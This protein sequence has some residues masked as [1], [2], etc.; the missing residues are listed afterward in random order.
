VSAFPSSPAS[1]DTWAGVEDNYQHN[2]AASAAALQVAFVPTP[3][4]SPLPFTPIHTPTPHNLFATLLTVAEEE[5]NQL[6]AAEVEVV[7]HFSPIASLGNQSPP[8][9]YSLPI[10][11]A[12]LLAYE[13]DIKEEPLGSPIVHTS[14]ATILLPALASH[15]ASPSH[16]TFGNHSASP[17]D[18]T[19]CSP[20]P[21][22]AT[23]SVQP[24]SP[25]LLQLPL[26]E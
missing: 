3:S 17:I 12:S 25:I 9:H 13:Q 14:I 5:H 20:T 7:D 6:L 18:Y 1:I 8:F 24:A 15:S 10:A 26:E 4:L 19:P 21:A 11:P 16:H 2:I 22:H 23:T